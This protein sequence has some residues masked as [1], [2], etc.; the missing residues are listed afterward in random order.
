MY[1]IKGE[2]RGPNGQVLQVISVWIRLHV[3]G[4]TRFVTLIPDKEARR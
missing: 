3:T 1:H 4:E 2:L